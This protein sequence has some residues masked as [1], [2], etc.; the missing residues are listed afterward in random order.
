M[1]KYF[2]ISQEKEYKDISTLIEKLRPKITSNTIIV[3]CSPDYSSIISQRVIHAYFDNP[4][5][6]ESFDMPFPNTPFEEVYPNYCK[7]FAQSLEPNTHYIFIDS[8]ILRGRNFKTLYD[9][10]LTNVHNF[11]FA[12]L[13]SQDDAIF[14]AD[15]CVEYF[16]KEE[17]GM[18]L[19]WWESE[20]CNLFGE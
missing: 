8:G 20:L 1:K 19:F 4:L 2:R 16:N 5:Q 17:Q 10:L 7:E 15:Y 18:L 14:E 3:N 9:N 12:C 11:D 13:Y 6:M